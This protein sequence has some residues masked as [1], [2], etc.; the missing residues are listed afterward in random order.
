MWNSSSIDI[1]DLVLKEQMIQK[2][3]KDELTGVG[4][5]EALFHALRLNLKEKWLI[6]INLVGFSEINDY[7]GFDIGDELLKHIA[8]V[9]LYG[10]YDQKGMVF[11]INGDEFAVLLYE[12]TLMR[13]EGLHDEIKKIVR[14]LEKRELS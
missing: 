3:F 11:R 2:H 1:T 5:R 7:L 12:E 9:L 8:H 13:K 6:L 4:N 10:F 14:D